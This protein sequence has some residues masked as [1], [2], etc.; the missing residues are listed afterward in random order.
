MHL[1]VRE[2]DRV[3]SSDCND[4]G[5]QVGVGR[6]ILLGA[7]VKPM[8]IERELLVLYQSTYATCSL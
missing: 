4:C 5:A 2:L 3:Y 7:N 1:N 6:P 8:A